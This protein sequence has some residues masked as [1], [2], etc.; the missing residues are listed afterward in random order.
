L[1]LDPSNVKLLPNTCGQ[2][3][4]TAELC[5]FIANNASEIS[6]N[7]EGLLTIEKPKVGLGISIEV[8]QKDAYKYQ[9]LW[10]QFM[11]IKRDLKRELDQNTKCD[12]KRYDEIRV[13]IDLLRKA[14]ADTLSRI[15]GLDKKYTTP[16]ALDKV[17]NDVKLKFDTF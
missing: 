6:I 17:N 13:D 14:N 10:W 3:S 5:D 15:D 9:V 8:N 4:T 7:T 16:A 11:Q 1:N 2:F 12:K